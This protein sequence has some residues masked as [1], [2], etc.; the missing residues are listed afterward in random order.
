MKRMWCV[1][2]VLSLLLIGCG[3]QQ[4]PAGA[5]TICVRADVLLEHTDELA[6]EKRE[7]VPYDGVLLTERTVTFYEGETAF[8]LLLRLAREEKLHLEFSKTPLYQ[9]VYVEGIGNLYEFD[10]GPGSGWMYLVNGASPNVSASEWSLQDGDVVA[11]CYTC[12]RGADLGLR[13]EGEP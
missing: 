1:I 12:D 4:T 9:S 11:W 6:P 2:L 8:D 10:C 5:C 13:V 7:L 3:K